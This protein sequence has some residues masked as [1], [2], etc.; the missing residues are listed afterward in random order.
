MN[1]LLKASLLAAALTLCCVSTAFAWHL[2]GHVVCKGTGL[3]FANVQINVVTT[4]NGPTLSSSAVTD[5]SGYYFITLLEEPREY[6]ATAAVSAGTTV[7]SPSSGFYAFATTSTEFELTRDWVLD[8]PTCTSGSTG[9]CWLTGG[10]AKFSPTTGTNVGDYTRDHNWGGNVNPGCSPTAGDGGSWNHIAARSRLHFHGQAIQ[11]VRCGNVDGIPPGSTSPATPFNFIE[12]KGTGTLKGIKGNKVN[13]GTVYF[14][15]R[16]EDR[17]EPGSR[18]Q[19]DGAGKDRYFLHVYANQANPNGST[20]LLV[21]VDGNPATVD[22]VTITD[23]N[24][25]IHVS[26][27]DRPPAAA[28]PLQRNPPEGRA[29]AAGS[30]SG[31]VSFAMPRP[32]PTI[33]RSLLSFALPRDAQVSLAIFDVT[34]RRMVDLASGGFPAG[35]HAVTWNLRSREGTRVPGGI[36]FARLSVEGRLITHSLVV[37]P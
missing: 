9:L 24:M 35:V 23:G 3:P 32:N 33:D 17:N 29:F 28:A 34:G 36:Y 19:R 15:A 27:C 25:Q 37:S 4:D 2:S 16:A 20:L 18:G 10:G 1:R 8:S 30:P 14:F 7:Y 5:E 13:Y 22:P 21:D 12:F 11:V 6:R 26:S 31:E